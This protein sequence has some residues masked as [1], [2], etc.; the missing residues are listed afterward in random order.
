MTLLETVI[1]N[2][3]CIGCGMC[4]AV[5]PELYSISLNEYGLYV[6]SSSSH[7]DTSALNVCPFAEGVPCEDDIAR[8]LYPSAQGY[9]QGVGYFASCYAGH[10]ASPQ[11]R[12]SSGSGGMGTWILLELLRAGYID[13]VLHVGGKYNDNSVPFLYTISTTEEEVKLRSKSRYYPVEMSQVLQELRKLDGRYAVVGLPCFI[14]GLRLLSSYDNQIADRIAYTVG[15]FCGHLKSSRFAD[16]FAWQLGIEPS[17]L[18]SVDFRVKLNDRPASDYGISVATGVNETCQPSSKFNYSSWGYGLFKYPACEYCDDLTGETAD[19]SVGDAWLPQYV[20]D[21]KGTN[22][23]VIRN[24]LICELVDA[25]I[26]R[27]DLLLTKISASEVSDSQEAGLRHKRLG[28]A[29]RLHCRD[30]AGRWRP[31][32]RVEPSN[33]LNSKQKRIYELR[34]KIALESHFAFAAAV[35]TKSLTHFYAL[36]KP[37]LYQYDTLYRP[38]ILASAKSALRKTLSYAKKSLFSAGI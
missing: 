36:M 31:T 5:S 26:L 20:G 37:L 27:G 28:L 8:E 6:A 1:A 11:I 21:S 24:T 25:A 30:M 4:A 12:E 19:I 18:T 32:K 7:V 34:E 14:K 23:V 2:N 9:Q 16:F 17:N 10:V 13:G 33:S 3:M 29:Y 38:S 22:V 15:L 35:Y